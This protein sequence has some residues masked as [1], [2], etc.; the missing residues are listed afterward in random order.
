VA[1]A[2]IASDAA[3][4]AAY[5]AEA[6][7]AWKGENPTPDENPPGADNGGA[8]F[9]PWD[10]SGGYHYPSQSPYGRLNHFIDGV[11]FAHSTYNNLGAPALGLTNANLAFGGATA[12]AT[13]TLLSSLTVGGVVSLDFDNPILNSF[14]DF[15][16]S[17]FII[18]LNSG[19]G[20]V[21][22][23]GVSER[24]GMFTTAG[25]LQGN[26]AVG[27]VSGKSDLGLS[28]VQTTAGATF[29]FTLTDS[30]TYKLE[31]LP[32]GGGVPLATR[33]GSLSNSGS[34]AIDSIEIVLFE[35]GSGNGLPGPGG[36]PTGER[37]F[38]FN[39][40]RIITPGVDGD[41]DGD[42]HVDGK[43][44]LVWQRTLGSAD[45]SADG[46]HN[47]TIDAGDLEVWKS[48]FAASP[49]TASSIAAATP[50]PAS[51]TLAFFCALAITGAARRQSR[52]GR[53]ATVLYKK[54]ANGETAFPS[55][56]GA[57]NQ[58]PRSTA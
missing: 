2:V 3:G 43:D 5:A 51:M 28:S 12:R 20:P 57:A 7:G 47:Y 25:Y 29:R 24:F 14:N 15:A 26:W 40:L 32:L 23:S 58:S 11:D 49:V 45:P 18:R 21:T 22:K 55:L 48:A 36:L 53:T 8:G 17:G 35:N 50:E 19:G 38:F 1:A 30:E 42:G 31:V 44:F 13:R 52:T 9:R 34:G 54:V 6:D 39:N 10:F 16:P 41:Y 4:D 27:D 37:E 33:T 56:A 46:D